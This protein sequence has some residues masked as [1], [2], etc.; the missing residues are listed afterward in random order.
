[1][2]PSFAVLLERCQTTFGA[3]LTSVLRTASPIT[4]TSLRTDGR[5]P[6]AVV[7][8]MNLI[9]ILYVLV[10]GAPFGQSANLTPFAPQGIPGIFAGAAIVYFS[11]VGFDTVATVA[12]EV[13]GY[14][15]SM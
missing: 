4:Q 7:R 15:Q 3:P 14:S 2:E 9:A 5:V 6:V 8:G 1:M 12:E 11:F 10:A 13:H